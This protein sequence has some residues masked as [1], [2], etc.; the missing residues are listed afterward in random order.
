MIPGYALPTPL[1]TV[2]LRIEDDYVTALEIVE[3]SVS[4]VADLPNQQSGQK[5]SGLVEGELREYFAG[6]RRSFSFPFHSRGTSFQ[7]QVWSVVSTIPYGTSVPYQSIAIKL[8]VGRE[9]A[10][11][12]RLAVVKNPIAIVIPCHRVRL[13]TEACIDEN[14]DLRAALRALEGANH[15]PK[16]TTLD[17]IPRNSS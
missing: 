14:C 8:G 9:G 11:D 3:P 12:V 5:L 4:E 13:A 17:F 16:H 7:R 10:E 1:G 6:R 2:N 15:K